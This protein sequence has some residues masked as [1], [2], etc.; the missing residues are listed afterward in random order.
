VL[1]TTESYRDRVHLASVT[2]NAPTG[3]DRPIS[4]AMR[5]VSQRA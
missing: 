2:G 4:A 3:L 1:Q 5:Q